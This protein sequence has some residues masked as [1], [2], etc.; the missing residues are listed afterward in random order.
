MF[1][2]ILFIF[3]LVSS[4]HAFAE[5]V[6]YVGHYELKGGDDLCSETAELELVN[7]SVTFTHGSMRQPFQW[8]EEN[9]SLNSFNHEPTHGFCKTETSGV[10]YFLPHE[11]RRLGQEWN[12]TEPVWSLTMTYTSTC[13][14]Q[15]SRRVILN[16]FSSDGEIPHEISYM[17][18]MNHVVRRCRYTKKDSI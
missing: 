9:T 4:P 2:Y 5:L 8:T 11:R 14:P 13:E 18:S 3:A 12:P 7:H 6:S 16:L 10:I 1:C 17:Y 15:S